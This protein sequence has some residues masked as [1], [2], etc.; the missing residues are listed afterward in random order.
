M[1]KYSEI[2]KQ[3]WAIINHKKNG[4]DIYFCHLLNK[5]MTKE[6]AFNTII[7]EINEHFP[8]FNTYK[9]LYSYYPNYIKRNNFS[10]AHNVVTNTTVIVP[11]SIVEIATQWELFDLAWIKLVGMGKTRQE[12]FDSLCSDIR[13]HFPMWIGVKNF[14]TYRKLY[15][16]RLHVMISNRAK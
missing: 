5:G 14:E 10:K 9:T 12:A 4:F 2:P 13:Y 7:D 3:I 6:E 8:D 11:N 1:K 15:E 16:K